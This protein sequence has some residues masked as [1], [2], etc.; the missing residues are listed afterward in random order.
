M[1]QS[2]HVPRVGKNLNS[3]NIQKNTVHKSVTGTGVVPNNSVRSSVSTGNNTSNK[4]IT[5]TRVVPNTFFGGS[6]GYLT[7]TGTGNGA[8][9]NINNAGTSVN[10]NLLYGNQHK[11]K[12]LNMAEF[13]EMLNSVSIKTDNIKYSGK[14]T[15]DT[16][17]ILLKDAGTIYYNKGWYY[18]DGKSTRDYKEVITWTLETLGLDIELTL[19]K[20]GG[21]NG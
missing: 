6:N 5:G 16:W 3:K 21:E 1:V 11:L 15:N 2:K 13:I 9:L 20:M 12:S 7:S 18:Y 14:N 10:Y 8:S 17:G 4:V 19:W